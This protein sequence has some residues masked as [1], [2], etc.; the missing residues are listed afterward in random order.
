MTSS[1][2]ADPET[3]HRL[4]AWSHLCRGWGLVVAHRLSGGVG[5]PRVRDYAGKGSRGCKSDLCGI[6]EA[7]LT[8]ER[9]LSHRAPFERDILRHLYVKRHLAGGGHSMRDIA[10]TIPYVV[11]HGERGYKALRI[12]RKRVAEAGVGELGL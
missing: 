4:R 10:Q 7:F 12:A 3:I 8:V 11:Q 2:L 1:T 6:G 9:F 5:Y